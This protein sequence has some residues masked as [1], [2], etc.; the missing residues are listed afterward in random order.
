MHLTKDHRQ[1]LLRDVDDGIKGCNAGQG[2]IGNIECQQV[3]FAKGNVGIQLSS[4]FQHAGRKIEAK[5]GCPGIAQIARDVAGTATHVAYIASSFGLFGKAVEQ[6]AIEGLVLEFIGNSSRVLLGK[7]I[8]AFADGACCFVVHE[9]RLRGQPRATVPTSS[10]LETYSSTL[11]S[12]FFRPQSAAACTNASTRGC[13]FP[14][15]EES[16]G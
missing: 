9:P 10:S 12:S 2:S 6:F 3:S 5:D 11:S 13:G 16:C 4:L 15:L 8:V 7:A 1:G 14:V